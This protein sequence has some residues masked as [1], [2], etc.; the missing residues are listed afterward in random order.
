MKP[1]LKVPFFPVFSQDN[2][3]RVLL[4]RGANKEVKN[5]NSQSP[6][7]VAII[8]GNFELAELVK[9]HKETDIVPF[10]EA[11]EYSKRRRVPPSTSSSGSCLVAP[12]VLLRSNSDNN[13]TVSQGPPQDW[14][15]P[16]GSPQHHGS[17]QGGVGP[18]TSTSHRSLSPQLLQQMQGNP[19]G[20]VRTM[21]QRSR[22]TS[23]GVVLRSPSPSLNRLGEEACRPHPQTHVQTQQTQH[24]K[25]SP[26]G[27]VEVVVQRRKLYSAVPGRHF[28][29]VHSY[30]P[31]AE[32]EITLYKNDRVKVLSIGEG[33]FWEGSARGQVGWFPAECVEEIP[34]KASE[35][36]TPHMLQNNA[37]P[38]GSIKECFFVL[39]V[40]SGPGVGTAATREASDS[41][42]GLSCLSWIDRF[43]RLSWI[44][45]FPCLS[46]FDGFHCLSSL[47]MFP[48]LSGF[49]RLPCLSGFDR[50]PC[51]SGFDRL[52]CL[53]W[54]NSLPCLSRFDR[55]PCL[56]GFDRLPCLSGFDRLPCLSGFDRLPCL[57]WVNRFPC[58]C[59][60]N[61][62][63]LSRLIRLSRLSRFVR[64]LCLSGDDQSAPD[65]Q[66]SSLWLAS[67]GWSCAP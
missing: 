64:F 12:R 58:L 36:R 61:Q 14:S 48:R 11:P 37:L 13:L 35:E 25:T 46:G 23:V 59:R 22:S 41:F 17:Q 2:C 65:P 6:F 24:R 33:G 30:H 8:A 60:R 63:G 45:R 47:D 52:P 5:Y 51:L 28:V 29:V 1:L 7:Q 67:C 20:T 55:L 9:N 40:M 16:Q 19:N 53:S 50:L 4:V 21:G 44:D 32:G 57:S 43:P 31:R 62:G 66:D 3:A 38:K 18:P 26:S 39:E 10:H 27:H 42:V 49:D 56:S 15:Q 34:A 54:L